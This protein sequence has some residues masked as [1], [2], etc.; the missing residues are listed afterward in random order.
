MIDYPLLI[1]KAIFLIILVYFIVFANGFMLSGKS[2][3]RNNCL[4]STLSILAS[5]IHFSSNVL[6]KVQ[7]CYLFSQQQSLLILIMELPLLIV[8]V[9]NY[10]QIKDFYLAMMS[11]ALHLT[12]YDLFTISS[13][14]FPYNHVIL[15]T[16]SSFFYQQVQIMFI[17][18][19]YNTLIYVIKLLSHRDSDESNEIILTFAIVSCSTFLIQL[20]YNYINKQTIDIHSQQKLQKLQYN[21]KTKKLKAE[22]QNVKKIYICFDQNIVCDKDCQELIQACFYQFQNCEIL[23]KFIKRTES[24][25]G[26]QKIEITESKYLNL[27]EKSLYKSQFA[28]KIKKINFLDYFNANQLTQALIKSGNLINFNLL[29]FDQNQ[30]KKEQKLAI[31]YLKIVK[32]YEV[33]QLSVLAYF[34]NISQYQT[35]NPNFIILDLYL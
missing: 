28:N 8:A 11:W 19:V 24:K 22:L 26:F 3:F 7:I 16:G 10:I 15:H 9:F 13:K 33:F 2:R 32:K 4:A 6:L 12:Q 23:S 18:K 21:E 29:Y 17:V 35:Y 27:I 31:N 20:Y 25:N 5:F 1:V 34:R 30:V 14:C